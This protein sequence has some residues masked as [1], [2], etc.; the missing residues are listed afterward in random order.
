MPK[1][2]RKRAIQALQHAYQAQIDG[3]LDRAIY[4][5][6]HSLEWYP[7]AEAHTYLGWAY[8]F[9]KDYERAMA[10]CRKAIDLDPDFGNPYNDIGAYLMELGREEEAIPWLKKAVAAKHYDCPWFP[11]YNLGRIWEGRHDWA[12]AELEFA[13]V[14]ELRPSFTAARKGLERVKGK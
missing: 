10:E 4:L 13:K 5:Y 1:S 14:L 9:K 3:D 12:A 7:T 8:S 6:L 11:H 2:N